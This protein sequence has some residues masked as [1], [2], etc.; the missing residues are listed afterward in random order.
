[1][2]AETD[3]ERAVREAD[4]QLVKISGSKA[5][6]ARGFEGRKEENIAQNVREG[7]TTKGK[8]IENRPDL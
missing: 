1:M 2:D 3:V 6:I 4:E 7:W 8:G 5:I